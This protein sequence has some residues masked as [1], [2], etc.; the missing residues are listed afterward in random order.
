MDFVSRTYKLG[1]NKKILPYL[2][3]S[4]SFDSFNYNKKTL[5]ENID[6]SINYAELCNDLDPSM[7]EKPEFKIVDEFDKEELVKIENNTFGFYLSNHPVQNKRDNNIDTRKIKE[8]FNKTIDIYLLVDN[9]KE[10]IT[11]N[12]EKMLFLTGSDE[13]S[14]I[15]LVIFPK[16]YEK[17]YNISKGDIIKFNCQVEK[18]GSSYQLIVNKLEKL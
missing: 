17:Y 6:L 15:E 4:G 12:K 2:I 13:F 10:V 18:R 7:I 1:I 3:Y 14:E 16:T 8:L 11:K 9:K 5:I